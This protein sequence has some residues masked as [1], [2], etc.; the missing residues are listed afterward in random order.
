MKTKFFPHNRVKNATAYAT[1]LKSHRVTMLENNIKIILITSCLSSIVTVIIVAFLLRNTAFVNVLEPRTAENSIKVGT[2]DE[3]STNRIAEGS[4]SNITSSVNLVRLPHAV[5]LGAVCLDGSQPAYY[6]R[7]G[8]GKGST[9]WLVHFFGGAWCFDEVSCV[10]RSKTILGSTKHLPA[11][12]PKLQGI[13]SGD[14]KVNPDFYNWN[15][16][17]LCYCDGASFTG[18]LS[19][20]ISVDGRNVYF[21]GKKILHVIMNELL[22]GELKNADKV[23]LSGTSAGALAAMMNADYIRERLPK[24]ADVRVFADSG[25]FIDVAAVNGQD[26]INRHFRNMVR[27][28]NSINYLDKDCIKA[29]KPTLRWKCIFPQHSIKY[30]QT[31][32]FVLQ[33]AYDPWQLINIRGINCQTP[34]YSDSFNVR[35][36]RIYRRSRETERVSDHSTWR[37]KHIHGIYCKPP[38]CTRLEMS[39]VLQYRNVSLFALRPVLLSKKNGLIVTSCLEHSQSVYDDTWNDVYVNG[40]SLSQAVGNWVFGRTAE[41]LYLDCEYPCN[42]SCSNVW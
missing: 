34:E 13:L 33:S 23:L 11:Y 3:S 5:K 35:R 7:K 27:V 17:L 39:S 30:I 12:P 15:A 19:Q 21:R 1:L 9:K 32:V 37:Y 6:F 2:R 28:H 26:I 8:H 22:L 42:P 20:P 4:T 29:L 38:E 24:S 18:Y 40:F 25:Y 10:Q 41:H 16:V 36:S 14:Y 31:P